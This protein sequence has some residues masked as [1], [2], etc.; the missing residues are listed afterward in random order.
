MFC[1]LFPTTPTI[2]DPYSTHGWQEGPRNFFSSSYLSRRGCRRSPGRADRRL[3]M[4]WGDVW[5]GGGSGSGGHAGAEGVK[6]G[7]G[8]SACQKRACA[9]CTAS[10]LWVSA[11]AAAWGWVPWGSSGCSSSGPAPPRRPRT[12]DAGIV[13]GGWRGE[14]RPVA[15]RGGSPSAGRGGREQ[16]AQESAP[17]PGAGGGAG[18]SR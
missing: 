4:S 3:R 13:A 17:S 1:K 12:L 2:R 7:R 6:Q 15:L 11:A 8:Q 16:A 9:V 10:V 5:V 18:A 14:A